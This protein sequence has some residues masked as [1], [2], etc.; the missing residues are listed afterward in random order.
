MTEIL[1]RL[2]PPRRPRANPR[3]IKRKMTSWKLKHPHHH[4]PPPPP[5]PTPVLT[6]PT[7]TTPTPR[8]PT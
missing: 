2:L 1:Q 4:N 6:T 8:K 7:R 3:V 5:H